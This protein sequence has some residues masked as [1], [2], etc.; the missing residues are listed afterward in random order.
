MLQRIN[1]I[2]IKSTK[3]ASANRE[4]LGFLIK[5]LITIKNRT[6]TS[7]L[8][9]EPH[10]GPQLTYSLLQNPSKKLHSG[11]LWSM[12]VVKMQGL[13]LSSTQV[14]ILILSVLT[15]MELLE[16]TPKNLY[17]VRMWKERCSFT[18]SHLSWVWGIQCMLVVGVS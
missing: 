2:L 12:T 17:R 1:N 16:L 13:T 14:E 6:F 8:Y 7:K 5:V 10:T 4:T 15:M 3:W 9:P 11:I 18:K